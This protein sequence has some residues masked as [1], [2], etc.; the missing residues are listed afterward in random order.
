MM[1]HHDQG[2][3]KERVY[4]GL[5]VSESES[6]KIMVGEQAAGRQVKFWWNST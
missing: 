2:N 4:L 1:K 5:I 6:M 3:I